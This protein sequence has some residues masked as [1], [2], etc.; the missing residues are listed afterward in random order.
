MANHH[1]HLENEVAVV[2]EVARVSR[3][4]ED[5]HGKVLHTLETMGNV[6][7]DV[8]ESHGQQRERQNGY[9][10]VVQFV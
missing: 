2:E 4:I 6:Q 8:C 5:A 9:R 1:H 7:N 10:V 3:E